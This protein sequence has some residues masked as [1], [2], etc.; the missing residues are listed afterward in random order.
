MLCFYGIGKYFRENIQGLYLALETV[1]TVSICNMRDV[2]ASG[3][4]FQKLKERK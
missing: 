4:I 1:K 2:C 3:V